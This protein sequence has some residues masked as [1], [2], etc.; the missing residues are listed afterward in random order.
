MKLYYTPAMPAHWI[1]E[2]DAQLKWIVPARHNGWAGRRPYQGNY[3]LEPAPEFCR[4]GLGL[5]TYPNATYHRDASGKLVRD[6]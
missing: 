3:T 2:D 6:L 5:N 4:I 1:V